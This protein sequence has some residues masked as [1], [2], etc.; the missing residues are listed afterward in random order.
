VNSIERQ[1]KVHQAINEQMQ[2]IKKGEELKRN[3]TEQHPSDKQL[4][5]PVLKL[6]E[7]FSDMSSE[8]MKSLIALTRLARREGIIIPTELTYW[9]IDYIANDFYGLNEPQLMKKAKSHNIDF[10]SSRMSNRYSF[11]TQNMVIGF[12]KG[13]KDK[14]EGTELKVT[15]NLKTLTVGTSKK[16]LTTMEYGYL[17]AQTKKKLTV[18]NAKLYFQKTLYKSDS[19]INRLFTTHGLNKIIAKVNNQK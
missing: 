4:P 3:I 11:D 15:G 8:A 5:S 1:K 9:M 19:V 18:E 2:T 16:I 12:E 13:L 10:D 6:L 17:L 7:K 14:Y